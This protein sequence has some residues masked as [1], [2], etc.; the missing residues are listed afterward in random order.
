MK[1]KIITIG[2]LL[3]ITSFTIYSQDFFIVK[4]DTI[5]CSNLI[6]SSTAQGYLKSIGY[7]DVNGKNISI[8][9]RK[10][11]PDVITF[12]ING[13]YIDK[14][15]L[16]ASKPNSYIR[17]TKRTVD[18]KLIV[19]LARQEHLDLFPMGSPHSDLNNRQGPAG[20]YR[21][22]LKIPNGTFYKINKNNIK[23]HIESYLLKC[24]DFK[25][26]YK[27]DYSPKEQPFMDMIRVYNS[28]CK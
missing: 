13:H 27:G 12:F 5:F 20:I 9:G 14:T 4:K 10:N 3:F 22:Y 8:K 17:Y 11:V 26:Q 2:I 23:N 24:T 19:Y 28:L 1:I 18:G 7:K 21:F 16:K 25:E 15:P 6:F